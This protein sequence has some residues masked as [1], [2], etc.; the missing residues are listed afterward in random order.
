MMGHKLQGSTVEKILVNDWFY[1]NNWAYVV[2]SRVRT[3]AGL[4]MRHPLMHN[5][6]KYRMPAAMKQMLKTFRDT[7]GLSEL[8]D[9][10]YSQLEHDTDFSDV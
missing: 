6:V 10:D 2:L 3:M 4:F 7:I 9:E 5:L 1:G 8:S